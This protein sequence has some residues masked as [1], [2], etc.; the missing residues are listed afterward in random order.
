MRFYHFQISE[1]F[2]SLKRFGDKFQCAAVSSVSLRALNATG[3]AFHFVAKIFHFAV[4]NSTFARRLSPPS[5]ADVHAYG[6]RNDGFLR[7]D[8][9][10]NH[11]TDSE[12]CVRHQRDVLIQT[13]QTRDIAKHILFVERKIV[14]NPC[15]NV[16]FRAQ[17]FSL[18][19]GI[20]SSFVEFKV[21][22]SRLS[23]KL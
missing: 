7:G 3:R 12:M 16:G 23:I 10:A 8:D 6:C 14:I 15:E 21:Q 2:P 13:R 18:L 22:V 17:I 11:R 4:K 20:F 1:L 5:T 9:R 19:Y